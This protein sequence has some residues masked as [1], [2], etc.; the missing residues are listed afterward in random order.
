MLTAGSYL[1]E[2]CLSPTYS[3]LISPGQQTSN[4]LHN[5]LKKRIIGINESELADLTS[6]LLGMLHPDP[7]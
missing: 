2:S 5:E 6:L 3:G 4:L 7:S 1:F